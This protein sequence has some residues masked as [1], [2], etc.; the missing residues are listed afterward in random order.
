M[1]THVYVHVCAQSVCVCGYVDVHAVRVLYFVLSLRPLFLCV[2]QPAA[3][4][5]VLPTFLVHCGKSNKQMK[6]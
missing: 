6:N 5:D 1:D 3:A 4:P 2:P